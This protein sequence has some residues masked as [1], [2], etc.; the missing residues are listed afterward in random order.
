MPKYVAG[1]VPGEVPGYVIQQPQPPQEPHELK[2]L[3]HGLLKE[4]APTIQKD[5]YE[6][7]GRLQQI[8][9]SVVGAELASLT[10]V[11]RYRGGVMTVAVSSGPLKSELD[12]FARAGLLQELA[13]RGLQ[14]IHNLKFRVGGGDS[15]VKDLEG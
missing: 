7:L 9:K 6:N 4:L 2:E 8:W 11:L 1:K 15:P 10:H 3:I 5:P 14:G 12:G 13:L